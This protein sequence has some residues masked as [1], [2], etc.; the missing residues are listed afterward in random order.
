MGEDRRGRPEA[1]GLLLPAPVV[2]RSFV[3]PRAL[4]PLVIP[5]PPTS[6]TRAG[7]TP[8]PAVQSGPVRAHPL[9]SPKH[10][11]AARR[12]DG[13]GDSWDPE[14]LAALLVCPDRAEEEPGLR[15]PCA[16]NGNVGLW[17]RD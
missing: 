16:G 13:H 7:V 8:S 6:D 12:W 17:C 2:P 10:P 5:S 11:R 1:R 4:L 15:G 3:S 14:E 9:S